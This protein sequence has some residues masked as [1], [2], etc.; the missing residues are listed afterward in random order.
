M[1]IKNP[2]HRPLKYKSAEQIQ[3]LIDKYFV[4]C[5]V[6]NK[7]Y[8]VCGLANALDMDRLSLINYSKREEFFNTIARAKQRIQQFYEEALYNNSNNN[9]RGVIFSLQANFGL[10]DNSAELQ[11]KEKEYKLKEKELNEKLKQPALNGVI[12]DNKIEI[13]VRNTTDEERIKKMEEDILNA[14]RSG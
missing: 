5:D 10:V 3:E 8:T 1:Y 12:P 11:L 7:P 14:N 4:D 13:V 2:R 6:R 9:A